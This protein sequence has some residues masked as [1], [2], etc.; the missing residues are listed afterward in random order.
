MLPETHRVRDYPLILG[1]QN[2]QESPNLQS[3]NLPI[4]RDWKCPGMTPGLHDFLVEAVRDALPWYVVWLFDHPVIFMVLA[5][6]IGVLVI[7]LMA[8]YA[9]MIFRALRVALTIAFFSSH[10]G[11]LCFAYVTLPKDATFLD[12]VSAFGLAILLPTRLALNFLLSPFTSIINTA[13]IIARIIA[14]PLL[15]VIDIQLH[16]L[17]GVTKALI[18]EMTLAY[19]TLV[20]CLFYHIQNQN[21]SES[22]ITTC[23]EVEAYGWTRKNQRE[24]KAID[25]ILPENETVTRK[26]H[27]KLITSLYHLRFATVGLIQFLAHSEDNKALLTLLNL[28]LAMLLALA[29]TP[30][31]DF[32]IVGFVV[33]VLFLIVGE[34]AN[35]KGKV[36]S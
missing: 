20:A 21:L 22:V 36:K 8:A 1:S 25:Y 17:L 18:V 29:I 26:L 9:K 33:Y 16:I 11:A 24:R 27:R 13:R 34:C 32:L 28:L 19:G 23:Q 30:V 10:I 15:R 31:R 14:G 6:G 2:L 4:S 7:R 35:G 3:R 12:M 5:V